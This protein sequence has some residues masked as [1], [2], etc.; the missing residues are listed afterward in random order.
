M[1]DISLL[2]VLFTIFIFLNNQIWWREFAGVI[3]DIC[4]LIYNTTSWVAGDDH[5]PQSHWQVGLMSVRNSLS[6]R[7]FHRNNLSFWPPTLQLIRSTRLTSATRITT[8]VCSSLFVSCLKTELCTIQKISRQKH[9]V[10]IRWCYSIWAH[11]S[12]LRTVDP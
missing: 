7:Q 10:R 2:L 5:Q 6:T 4:N 1:P 8:L 12:C 11:D 3:P 9:V